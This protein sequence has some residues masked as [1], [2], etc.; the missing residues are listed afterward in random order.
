MQLANK[1]GIRCDLCALPCQEQFEYYSLESKRLNVLGAMSNTF[2][3]DFNK[4]MCKACYDKLLERVK[5][6]LSA[7]KRL[8]VKCD[9]C[10]KYYSGQFTY[11][12]LLFSLVNVDIAR[13]KPVQIDRNVMDLSIGQCCLKEL[14]AQVKNTVD[15]VKREGDW[16]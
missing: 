4:D 9:L 16:A 15:M 10:P 11:T 5:Q 14:E 8:S 7:I 2:P 3:A 12:K 1:K 6:F 13:E